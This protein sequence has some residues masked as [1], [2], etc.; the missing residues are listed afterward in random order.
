LVSLVRFFYGGALEVAQ[1]T[2]DGVWLHETEACSA[3]KRLC[4]SY[5]KRHLLQLDASSHLLDAAAFYR[6]VLILSLELA[7]R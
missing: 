5:A 1:T 3:G 7:S 6:R 2:L 4:A